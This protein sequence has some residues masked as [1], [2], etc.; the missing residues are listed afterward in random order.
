VEEDVPK[1]A[2]FRYRPKTVDCEA[3]PPAIAM[4]L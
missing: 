2:T 1:R 4:T 3:M